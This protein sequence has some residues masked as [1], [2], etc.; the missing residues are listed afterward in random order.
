MTDE[1][2]R[3]ELGTFPGVMG[4]HSARA[5]ERLKAGQPGDLVTRDEMALVIGRGCKTHELGYG[6]VNT[7]IRHTERHAGI[8]WRWDREAQAWRCLSDQ[9]KIKVERDYTKQSR[10]KARR[11]MI[12]GGTVDQSKLT[13]DERRE[14]QLNLSATGMIYLCGGGAFR[15]RMAGAGVGQ[16]IQPEPDKLIALMKQNT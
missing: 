16:L 9:H 3:P 12:V 6:N 10:A 7:A 13:D 4:P 2:I 15:K 1:P 8:V 14:H 5:V 11:G